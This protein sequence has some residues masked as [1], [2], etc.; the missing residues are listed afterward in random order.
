MS[1]RF[2]VATVSTIALLSTAC[3]ASPGSSRGTY[4][5]WVTFE[6]PVNDNVLL[7]WPQ[8]QMPLRVHL[9]D[10]PEGLFAD[11]AAVSGAVRAG[12][13]D[14]SDVVAPGLPSF[15]FVDDPG[16][17][18]IP[19]VWAAE[20][21]GDWYVA[22]CAYAINPMQRRFGVSRIVVTGRWGDQ[23]VAEV[24]EIYETMLHEMGHALG[25][26]GHSPDPG[27]IMYASIRGA[28]TT[29]SE[30]DRQTLIALYER[31]IGKRVVGAKRE[32]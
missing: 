7:R 14:W 4:L 30:R 3:A 9:P 8:R 25:L 2:F 22:H 19:I 28:A 18:D 12:V 5:R 13:L 15:T 11:P 29:L 20:P 27:D 31:P 23:R 26:G 24:E 1:G 6:M 32:R 10:P 16:A 17:A 21:D